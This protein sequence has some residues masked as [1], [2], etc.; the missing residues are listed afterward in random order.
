MDE[1]L[2]IQMQEAKKSIVISLNWILFGIIITIFSWMFAEE[3]KTYLI[4]WG[5]IAYGIFKF[6]HSL[7]KFLSIKSKYNSNKYQ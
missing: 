1:L 5:A 6:V 2:E 4:F 7:D 3:G